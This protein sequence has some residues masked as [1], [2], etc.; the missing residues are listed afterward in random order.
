M[1]TKNNI[2]NNWLKPIEKMERAKP[3]EELFFKIK[4]ELFASKVIPLRQIIM[5]AASILLLIAANVVALQ[6]Y[7]STSSNNTYS[8][9]LLT[10][11]QIY[12]YED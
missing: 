4:E 3:S 8:S 1:E 7:N 12:N 2:D 5:V 6:A 11:Y 10:D 9:E